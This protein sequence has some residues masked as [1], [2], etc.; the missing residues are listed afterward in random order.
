MQVT[1]ENTDQSLLLLANEDGQY[2]LWPTNV[3]PPGGWQQAL[4]TGDR[5]E[6]IRS[7]LQEMPAIKPV[8]FEKAGPG[9]RVVA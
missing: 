6:F 3:E 5:K 4:T 7:L 9:N 1:V 8:T 2:C